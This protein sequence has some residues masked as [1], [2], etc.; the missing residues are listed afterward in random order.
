MKK[1]TLESLGTFWRPDP[2]R[3]TLK[4]DQNWCQPKIWSKLIQIKN[5]P[6]LIL[7]KITLK[8]ICY[9]KST[10]I[11]F[12]QKIGTK[13]EKHGWTFSCG[14]CQFHKIYNFFFFSYFENFII[15]HTT[16]L[17]LSK[18]NDSSVFRNFVEFES[19]AKEVMIEDI[20]SFV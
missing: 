1:L 9:Q 7:I 11:D 3:F 5:W 6:Q 8:F 17:V 20:V 12:W 4:M 13:F 14:N 2:N 10:I 19:I 15:F 18:F 16:F